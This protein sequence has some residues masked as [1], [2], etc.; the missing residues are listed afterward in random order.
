MPP[1]GQLV[2]RQAAQIP[3]KRV[4]IAAS[5]SCIFSLWLENVW[6]SRVQPSYIRS[7]TEIKYM[8][9][10]MQK[11]PGS[12]NGICCMMVNVWDLRK[13]LYC[14]CNRIYGTQVWIRIKF[15]IQCLLLTCITNFHQNLLHDFGHKTDVYRRAI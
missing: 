4:R 9:Y 14:L 8:A 6:P 2:I 11:K 5:P 3:M 12:K 13:Y 7:T 15:C 10:A 1:F